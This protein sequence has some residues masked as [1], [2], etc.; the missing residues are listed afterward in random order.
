MT[1]PKLQAREANAWR[2]F[3]LTLLWTGA[4]WGLA[5]ASPQ[6]WTQWP[7]VFLYIIGGFGPSL[8]ALGL[9]YGGYTTERP[10]RFWSRVIDPC[11]IPAVWYLV[12]V[13]VAFGPSLLATLAPADSGSSVNGGQ[14]SVTLALVLVAVLAGLAEE[15]GWRGYALDHLL[16]ARSALTT[17][18]IVGLVWT[19]WHLPLYFIGGTIQNESGLWSQDFWVDMT[20]RVPLAV[21]FAWIYVNTRRSI[22]GAILLHALDNIASVAIAPEGDQLIARLAILVG[23]ATLIVAIWGP[24]RLKR[25]PAG[26]QDAGG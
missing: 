3:A 14:E 15:L 13:A 6:E 19:V 8:V 10:R 1:N 26:G 2:F 4:L 16:F 18:L 5:A 11:R 17:S 25:G 9:V 21:L 20:G 24:R 12:I 23:L 7:T 22:L